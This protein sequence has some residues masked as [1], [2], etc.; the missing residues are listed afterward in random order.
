MNS[1]ATSQSVWIGTIFNNKLSHIRVSRMSVTGFDGRHQ[2]HYTRNRFRKNPSLVLIT[3]SSFHCRFISRQFISCDLN[4]SYHATF[5]V[6][7][8]PGPVIPITKWLLPRLS[9]I[10]NTQSILWE[11]TLTIVW[12]SEWRWCYNIL[13]GNIT[14]VYYITR[15]HSYLLYSVSIIVPKW[16]LYNII[17]FFKFRFKL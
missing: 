15:T 2:C 14:L 7:I 12:H 11:G 6:S 5:A 9:N 10:A 17:T 1:V 4:I 3:L 16:Y 8:S 13:Y